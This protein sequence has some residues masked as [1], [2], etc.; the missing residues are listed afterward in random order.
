MRQLLPLDPAAYAPHFIHGSERVWGE[1]NCYIDLWVEVLN[2]LG[3]DPVPA[4]VCALDADFDGHSWAFLK[5]ELED[6]RRLYGLVVAE[7]NI[8]RPVVDHIDEYLSTGQLLTVEVDSWWLPD[9][10]GTAYQNEH[11][12]T[13]VVANLLDRVARRLGYWHNA[14]YF[15]LSGDDFDHIFR[16]GEHANPEVLPPYVELVRLDKLRRDPDDL[17]A[18]TVALVREHLSRRPETNPVRR[19]ADAVI[20]ALPGLGEQGME[21]FH[22]YAFATLRQCGATAELGADLLAWL[23]D[24]GAGDL[25]D[26]ATHLRDVAVSAKSAQFGMARAARGR[27]VDLGG[28]L[29]AMAGS[30]EQ[31]Q[32]ALTAWDARGA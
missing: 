10:A 23:T 13:T 7:C 17:L 3:L 14:G 5:Y 32:Q 12:K 2:S 9:T 29:D 18:T 25:E 30:W 4:A 6:L 20:A 28:P 31:A 21:T 8:W 22:L 24:R 26:A 27:S 15:E 11:V 1:T 19:L 16:L